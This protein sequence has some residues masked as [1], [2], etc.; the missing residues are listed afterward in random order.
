MPWGDERS[1]R[2]CLRLAFTFMLEKGSSEG[3]NK[4]TI[5]NFFY[6]PLGAQAREW[7][8]GVGEIRIRV[9]C[10]SEFSGW[11]ERHEMSRQRTFHFS[12][13]KQIYDKT[14]IFSLCA[15]IDG[16]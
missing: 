5:V 16:R 6:R 13:Q 2:G 1:E 3:Q 8:E 15:Q 11:A 14:K 4:S 12:Y 9:A 7:E 10:N